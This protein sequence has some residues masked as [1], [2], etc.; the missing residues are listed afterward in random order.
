MGTATPVDETVTS[1]STSLHARPATVRLSTVTCLSRSIALSMYR[2]FFSSKLWA[3]SYH[4]MG[5]AA[6]RV[7]ISAFRKSCFRRPRLAGGT[8]KERWKKPIA[9]F[10]GTRWGGTAVAS[11]AIRGQGWLDPAVIG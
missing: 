1:V 11:D 5:A 8:S 4:W 2:L 3:C 10:W 6:Y 9:S 7:S